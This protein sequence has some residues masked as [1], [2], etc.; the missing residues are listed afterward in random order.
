[1]KSANPTDGVRDGIESEVRLSVKAC[2]AHIG[3]LR[4]TVEEIVRAR[5]EGPQGIAHLHGGGLCT[6]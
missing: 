6:S 5:R 4:S 2:Q 1:V 3:L